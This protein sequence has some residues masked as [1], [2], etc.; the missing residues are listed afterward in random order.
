MDN[1]RPQ[2]PPLTLL[3]RYRGKGFTA[4]YTTTVTVA[5]GQAAHGRASGIARSDDGNLILDLRLPAAMGGPGNGTNPE[6]LFAAGFAAC[7]HGALSLVARR[8]QVDMAHATVAAEV[9]FGR[10]PMDG[11]Y[12]LIAEIRIRMPGVPRPVAEDLVRSTER[13][14]PY[15]K[16]ARDGIYSVVSVI[17]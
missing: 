14:C 4:L 15:A 11:G 13:L 12:A 1:E 6:Q 16:M 2:P 7:F 10:D 8:A 17:D 3:D 5:G 9:S